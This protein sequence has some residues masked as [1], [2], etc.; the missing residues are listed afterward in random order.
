[1]QAVRAVVDASVVVKWIFPDTEN[2]ADTRTALALLRAI[3][4]GSVQVVQPSH[5]L[6]EVAAVLARLVPEAAHEEVGLLYAMEIPVMETLE[7]YEQAC[8][9]AVRFEHHLFDTLYHAVALCALDTT[10]V[11]ADER[12]YRKAHSAGCMMRLGDFLIPA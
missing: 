2:E 5:W 8:E 11:T 6:A 3:Q 1:M 10:L 4:S 7:V 9:L 12:Y